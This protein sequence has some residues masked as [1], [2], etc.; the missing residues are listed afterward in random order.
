MQILC[1]TGALIGR[2]NGRDYHVLEAQAP[3]LHCDGFEFILY[4]TWYDQIDALTAFLKTLKLN[5]LVMHCEKTMAMPPSVVIF[6]IKTSPP[7]CTGQPA[8][9]FCT[10]S[11][12]SLCGNT[13]TS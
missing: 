2:P 8:H 6:S 10:A 7:A 1:S 4:T 5:I 11:A 9:I 3:R 13:A 12:T